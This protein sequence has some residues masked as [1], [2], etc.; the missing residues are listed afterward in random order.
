MSCV[1][2]WFSIYICAV[3]VVLELKPIIKRDEHKKKATGFFIHLPLS[4][5]SSKHNKSLY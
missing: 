5:E 4:D 3:F 2:K 1:H